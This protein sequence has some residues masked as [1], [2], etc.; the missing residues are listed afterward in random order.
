MNWRHKDIWNYREQTFSVEI[1]RWTDDS[2]WN[3]EGPNRWNVYA[4]IYPKHPHFA[5][6]E[7][8][9]IFQSAARSLPLHCGASRVIVHRNADG[10]IAS[11]Q[12]GSDYHHSYD[13]GFT[14]MGTQEEAGEVFADAERLIEWLHTSEEVKP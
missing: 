5:F 8:D 7:G 11:Y 2:S 4:Y 13:E 1:V 10:T 9:N 6:F 12:I 3:D 14:F